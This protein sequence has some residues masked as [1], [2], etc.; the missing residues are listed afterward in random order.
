MKESDKKHTERRTLFVDLAR[1][2]VTRADKEIHIR[3]Y[4]AVFFEEGNPG[5]EYMLWENY[6]ERI[7]AG[8]FADVLKE[9]VRGLFN[10]DT[11]HILG[12]TKSKTLSIGEDEKGLWYDIL[13]P[14]TQ[15]A[16]D[17]VISIER[18]DVT[19]SSFSFLP[20]V[21]E[22]LDTENQYIRTVKKVSALFDVGPVTFP[23][24][25]G[26]EAAI[27]STGDAEWLKRELDEY[28]EKHRDA[29]TDALDMDLDLMEKRLELDA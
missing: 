12:R 20:E 3:G 11:D 21:T 1:A 18:G 28:Q 29:L 23:A 13:A 16:K 17:L 6:K 25:E 10:H 14:G 5:T 9:D 4:A 24:Y 8:A 19:G 26:T 27:R 2:T 7:A 15:T 22:I